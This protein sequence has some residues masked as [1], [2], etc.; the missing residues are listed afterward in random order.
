MIRNERLKLSCGTLVAMTSMVLFLFG[1]DAEE[2]VDT[3]PCTDLGWADYGD[4]FFRD[5]CRSCHGVASPN[6][7]GAPEGMDFDTLEDIHAWE[8]AIYS[9]TVVNQTMPRG[10]GMREEDRVELAA[11]LD[12]GAPP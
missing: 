2:P 5:W 8:S 3:A 4:P 1:C 6:R 10:G 7:Y 9:S 11:W 12:C